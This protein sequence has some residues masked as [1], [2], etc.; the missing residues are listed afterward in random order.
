MRYE[1][2]IAQRMKL[3][4]ASKRGSLSLSIALA[5]IVLAVVVMI[6][7]ITVMTGFRDEITTKIYSLDP[8]IKISNA[9][10]GI[11]DNYATINAQEALTSIRGDS[12]LCN[13]LASIALIADKPAILKTDT[14]FKGIQFRGVDA[15][16]DW[17]YLQA[18]LV[19]GRVPA[20]TAQNEI[21]MSK[22]VADQLRLHVGDKVLTYFIDEKVKV[23]NVLIV[24]VYNTNFDTFDGT[25]LMG[26]I[27]LIQRI[28]GWGCDTGNFIGVNLRDLDH[29]H[30]DAYRTYST[31]ARGTCD[32]HTN[33]L[34]YVTHT[35]ENNM[36]F[37]AWLDMLDMNVV[38][39]LVLMMVVSAF[40][41]I[42]ALLMIVLERIRMIGLLK[43]LGATNRSVRRVFILLTQKLVLKALVLGN[44]LGLGLALAQ[45]WLHIVRLDPDA[46]YMPYVPVS[47][48]WLALLMLNVGIVV[49]SYLT[50]IGPSLIISTIK[51][52]STMRF[53]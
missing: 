34:F 14:D 19:A 28:N 4:E 12:A 37:F 47:I 6:V 40:T 13:R 18:H 22:I 50:L 5:G 8:H 26:N 29:L 45:K 17:S 20:D 38:I 53:E 16:F 49:I 21:V 36:A 1:F 42:S 33:T 43:A 35:R 48:D 25:L 41:L 30:D 7:S 10:L 46:Y 3:G 23:R 44:L 9:V 32:R 11:D 52:T 39:I 24:G 27:A 2:F 31:L 51:P 15:G